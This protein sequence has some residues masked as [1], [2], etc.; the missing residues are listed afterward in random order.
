MSKRGVLFVLIS[1]HRHNDNT[2]TKTQ[3]KPTN[4]FVHEVSTG[5]KVELLPVRVLA[6]KGGQ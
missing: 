2:D 5:S 3:R 4:L 6:I 1:G